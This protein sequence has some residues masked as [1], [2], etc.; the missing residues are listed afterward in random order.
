MCCIIRGWF[1]AL[2][3]SNVSLQSTH[4]V[5]FHTTPP[6]SITPSLTLFTYFPTFCVRSDLSVSHF[7]SLYT[8]KVAMAKMY[9][10]LIW[11]CFFFLETIVNL[12]F[13][14]IFLKHEDIHC[15]KR[16]K[17]LSCKWRFSLVNRTRRYYIVN[18]ITVFYIVVYYYDVIY[19][20]FVSWLVNIAVT[21][22][23][24]TVIWCWTDLMRIMSHDFI[25]LLPR[26]LCCSLPP[27][28]NKGYLKLSSYSKCMYMDS[29][30]T[31]QCES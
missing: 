21:Q 24:N 23:R 25:F 20:M 29:I 26:S 15:K 13:L 6:Q 7:L 5:L 10:I 18:V 4:P 9:N 8:F 28:H 27:C 12:R 30:Y 16:Y 31:A 2:L 19:C 1:S 22:L 11:V 17:Y 3:H 14:K